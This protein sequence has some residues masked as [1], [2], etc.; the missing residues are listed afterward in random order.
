MLRSENSQRD[1]KEYGS[2]DDQFVE[3]DRGCQFPSNR[4]QSGNEKGQSCKPRPEYK[5]CEHK[6]LHSLRVR[7]LIHRYATTAANGITLYLTK[8]PAI[9]HTRAALPRS[10]LISTPK[11]WLTRELMFVRAAWKSSTRFAINKTRD[12]PPM[13]QPAFPQSGCSG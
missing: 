1:S 6:T 13:R 2:Q 10:Y 4:H 8:S 9:T 3:F 11:T 7:H 12:G 5:L